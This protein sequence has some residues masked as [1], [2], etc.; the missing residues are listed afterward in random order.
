[1]TTTHNSPSRDLTS[2]GVNDALRLCEQ[3]TDIDTILALTHHPVPSVRKRALVEMC[4][5]R[6]Q[7]DLSEFWERVFEMISDEDANVRYQVLHTLCDGSPAHLE[8]RVAEALDTFNRD[9]DQ[10]IRRKAHQCLT[11]Y[12]RKGKWNIM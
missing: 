8:L 4:P 6:V 11:S 3:T 7:E 12:W 9:P 1:M 5:C 2:L 10:K